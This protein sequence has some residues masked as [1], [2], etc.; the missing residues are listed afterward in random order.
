[1]RSTLEKHGELQ[2]LTMMGDEDIDD[3]REKNGALKK[4]RI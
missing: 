3:K 4:M 1:M 2:Y